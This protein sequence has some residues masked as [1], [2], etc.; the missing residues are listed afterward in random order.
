[1]KPIGAFALGGVLAT[2]LVLLGLTFLR[3]MDRDATPATPA[4]PADTSA[5]RALGKVAPQQVVA[6]MVFEQSGQ[7]LSPEEMQQEGARRAQQQ[8]QFFEKAFAADAP[9]AAQGTGIEGQWFDALQVP[10][11]REARNQ[12]LDFSVMC[13]SSLCRMEAAF[14]SMEESDDWTTRMHLQM[15]GAIGRTTTVILPGPEGQ[16]KVV[17]Y[18]YR[19]GREPRRR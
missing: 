19:L 14:P 7:P 10:M 15:G 12:P 3:P 13:K 18:A 4:A 17:V 1:M 8:S 16:K 6:G 2:T 11:V 9:D 5:A